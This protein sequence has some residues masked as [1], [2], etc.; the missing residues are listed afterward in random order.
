MWASTAM[1]PDTRARQPRDGL[2]QCGNQPADISVIHRR[3]K[4]RASRSQSRAIP[5]HTHHGRRLPE[6][7]LSLLTPQGHIRTYS[8]SLNLIPSNLR[9]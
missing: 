3:S 2:M 4:L 9:Q 1:I 6:L 7:C 5:S 8:D